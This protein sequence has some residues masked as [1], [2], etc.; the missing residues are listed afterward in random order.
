[1]IKSKL[2][3]VS[4]RFRRLICRYSAHDWYALAYPPARRSEC[5]RCGMI[6]E[7]VPFAGSEHGRQPRV[8]SDRADRPTPG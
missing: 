6:V 5:L 4:R 8:E 2:A 3:A 1:M 7:E